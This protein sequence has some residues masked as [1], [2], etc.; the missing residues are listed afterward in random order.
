[1]SQETL[2]NERAADAVTTDLKITRTAT[3]R[4]LFLC[5]VAFLSLQDTKHYSLLTKEAKSLIQ[6]TSDSLLELDTQLRPLAAHPNNKWLQKVL[7]RDELASVGETIDTFSQIRTEEEAKLY[8]VVS[9][10]YSTINSVSKRKQPLNM[11]KYMR[12][13]NLVKE[14]MEADLSGG[15]PVFQVKDGDVIM[16]VPSVPLTV[17]LRPVTNFKTTIAHE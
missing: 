11:D 2:F 7:S 13:L 10:L 8:S 12:L 9:D 15:E 17:S 4:S 3:M 5:K 6:K 16:M 14:E 1:M